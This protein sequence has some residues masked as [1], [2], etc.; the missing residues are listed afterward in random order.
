MTLL[1]G[2]KLEGVQRW[3]VWCPRCRKWG[4]GRRSLALDARDEAREAR[5]RQGRK[6]RVESAVYEGP[7][8]GLYHVTSQGRKG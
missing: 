7:V 8:C 1:E 4:Y 3:R 6:K 2:T 5:I